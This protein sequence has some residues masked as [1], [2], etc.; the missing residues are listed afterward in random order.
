MCERTQEHLTT[1]V[2]MAD[3]TNIRM[4]LVNTKICTWFYINIT[5]FLH[6]TNTKIFQESNNVGVGFYKHLKNPGSGS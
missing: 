2:A 4:A 3:K 1:K 6:N 5:S